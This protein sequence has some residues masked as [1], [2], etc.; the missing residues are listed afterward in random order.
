[1]KMMID[2]TIYASYVTPTRP[3]K[4]R[5]KTSQLIIH[6]TGTPEGQPCTVLNID[7]YH[8]EHNNWACIGYHFVIYADGKVVRGRPEAAIGSH[9][10]GQNANSI[11]IAYVGGLTE[12]GKKTKDTRTEQQKVALV[13]L[14]KY[15]MGKYDITPAHVH[16]HNEYTTSKACPCFNVQELR[17]ELAK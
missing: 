16:G 14:C 8:K 17:A 7:K 6:C 13:W 11:G 10:K 4:D 2:T 3:L 15:L 5:S 9:C 12:D 1:M